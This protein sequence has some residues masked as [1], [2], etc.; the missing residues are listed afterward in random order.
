MT[1]GQR[2]VGFDDG[3]AEAGFDEPVPVYELVQVVERA[4]DRWSVAPLDAA[5]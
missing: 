3:E 1:V 2:E 5:G 4:V